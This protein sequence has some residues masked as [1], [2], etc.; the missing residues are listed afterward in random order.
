MVVR[1][2]TMS[3]FAG[4]LQFTTEET[5]YYR[6]RSIPDKIIYEVLT[7]NANQSA[8]DNKCWCVSM[9][10]NFSICVLLINV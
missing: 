2:E 5:A 7:S 8:Q 6:K 1:R 3:K 4:K 9:E 10:T